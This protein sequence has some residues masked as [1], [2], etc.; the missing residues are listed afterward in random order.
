MEVSKYGRPSTHVEGP[1]QQNHHVMNV[2]ILSKQHE[3]KKM[4]EKKTLNRMKM[5]AKKEWD[6]L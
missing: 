2:R 5:K 6:E 1:R 4:N 3:R